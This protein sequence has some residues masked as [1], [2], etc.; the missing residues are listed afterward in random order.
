MYIYR[1]TLP[2]GGI[3]RGS[4]NQTQFEGSLVEFSCEGS[5]DHFNWLIAGPTCDQDDLMWQRVGPAQYTEVSSNATEAGLT[6]STMVLMAHREYNL[7][8]VRCEAICGGELCGRSEEAV[9]TVKSESE[10]PTRENIHN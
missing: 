3:V 10:M 1:T 8:R 2:P 9:L 7:S 5:V 6:V 4:Q